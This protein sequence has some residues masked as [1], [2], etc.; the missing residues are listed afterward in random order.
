MSRILVRA[1]A[2][3]LL[4]AT[5]LAPAARAQGVEPN[6]TPLRTTLAEITTV[7]TEYVEAYNKKDAK[8]V[9]ALYTP[10][11][12]HIMADGSV[13]NGGAAI[14]EGMAKDAPNWPHAVIKSD[15]V[16]VY[17]ATAVDMGTWT[18]HPKEGGEV[19]SRY[20]TV[21]R[22]DMRGWKLANVVVVPMSK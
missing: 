10:N 2:P 17:G 4:A 3:L 15:T 8:A 22:R 13:V 20:I 12:V 7:R 19:V 16:H 21:L 6:R 14:S 1:A 18:V 5:I 9:S 11:A